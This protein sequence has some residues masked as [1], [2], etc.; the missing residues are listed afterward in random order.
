MCIFGDSVGYLIFIS[1]TQTER[2]YGG[3]MTYQGDIR[4]I[5]TSVLQR[6]ILYG[7]AVHCLYTQYMKPSKRILLEF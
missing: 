6:G 2:K 3:T 5:E 7:G 4:Q 1:E